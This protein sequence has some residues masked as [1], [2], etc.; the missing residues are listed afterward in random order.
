M[1]HWII[2][3]DHEL[4]SPG[5]RIPF[6]PLAIREGKG[7]TIVSQ[8][9][10]RYIDFLAGACVLN[11]G[12]THP[13]IVHAIKMQADKFLSYNPAY[14]YSQP[15]ID[16]AVALCRIT[17][18]DFPKRIAYGLSGADA[19]DGMIKMARSS[20]GRQK[21]ISF[22]NS[23]HG[24]TYGALSLSGHNL[25]MRRRFGPFLP[26][27]YHVP[28]ADCYRCPFHQTYPGCGIACLEYIQGLLESIIP[29]EEVAAVIFEPIQGDAGIIIPPK[30]FVCG[31]KQICE[32][33]GILFVSEE[34]QSGFG[35]TGKWF[36]TEH[37]GIEP[38]TIILGKAIASGMP[39]SAIVARKALMESWG[40]VAHALSL[41]ANPLSC[42]ASL[43]TIEVIEEEHLVERSREEGEYLKTRF[44]EMKER[45]ELIGDVRGKGLMIG[46]D[47]VQDRKT[48]IRARKETAK[49]CW[50]CWEKGLLLTLFSG[51]VLRIAPPLVI[52]RKEID[53]ALDIIDASLQ[54]V[55]DGKVPDEVLDRIKGW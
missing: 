36:A 22:Q 44:S 30:E 12:H 48:K 4:I 52:T 2:R 40:P 24:A 19:N 42:V 9:G 46:V 20:T 39:L 25:N 1:E 16:L 55:T 37:W 10:K 34:V 18:G 28:Y 53:D 7:S 47:L 41:A 50:R 6:Y 21:V 8:E 38:D 31:L 29:P 13:K 23:Y 5:A 45:Y 11:T 17:P 27:I 32:K 54:D 49:V 51:S 43:M 15:M 14:V 33:N 26:E 3:E 35:R